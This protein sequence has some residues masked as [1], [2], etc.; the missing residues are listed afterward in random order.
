MKLIT[1]K[2]FISIK[3]YNDL[4]MLD[5]FLSNFSVSS[6]SCFKDNIWFLDTKPDL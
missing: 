1:E 2:D 4:N 3:N 5:D 6:I